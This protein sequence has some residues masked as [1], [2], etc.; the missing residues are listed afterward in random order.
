MRRPGQTRE[1]KA[2]AREQRALL[3]LRRA[4]VRYSVWMEGPDNSSSAAALVFA[5]LEA[6]CDAYANV[7][8]ARE[9][10][11]LSK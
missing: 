3:R 5:D 11:R 9:R 7:L 10:A 4:A 8:G 6:A 1:Q 2:H